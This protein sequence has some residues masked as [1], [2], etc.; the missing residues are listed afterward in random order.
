MTEALQLT[1]VEKVLEIGTGSGYQTAVLAELANRVVSVERIG[2]LAARAR[3]TLEALGYHN[4]VIHTADGTLGWREG[5]PYDAILV[6]AGSP[7]I[8][9]EL[10]SQLA[11][12]GRLVI[13]V[14]SRHHQ[15][16]VRLTLKDG[17][18]EKEDLG[19]CI[20]VPLIGRKGWPDTVK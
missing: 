7:E 13:P 9:E 17:A 2:E 8:P 1:G 18:Q 4:V 3:K 12:G 15:S 11:E 20:F 10:V 5:A 16:L 6:T 14:G 19:G